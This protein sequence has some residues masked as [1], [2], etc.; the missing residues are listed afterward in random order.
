M[1][2][3][4]WRVIPGK[5]WMKITLLAAGAVIVTALLM[6]FAFPWIDNLMASQESA[7]G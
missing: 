2:A 3:A 5:R 1:Y 4:L 6:M 7:V